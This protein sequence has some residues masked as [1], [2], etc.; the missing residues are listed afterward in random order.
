MLLH[1]LTLTN[2]GVYRGQ[3]RIR[4]SSTTSRPITLIGGR[5]GAGKTS[6]LDSIPLVLYGSRARRVL[7]G[8]AYPEH[9]NNLVH[10]GERTASIVIAFDRAEEGRQVR[11]VV[12]RT[13][14]RS[15]RGRTTDRLFVSIDGEPRSDLV[16]AWPEFVEGIMPLAV[17]DLAIFDGE[18]I[19]SLADPLSSAAVLRT[20]LYGLLGLDLVDR[21]RTDLQ[22]YRRRAAKAHDSERLGHLSARLHEAEAR[23]EQARVEQD[24]A[25]QALEAAENARTD[26]DRQLQK[27]TDTLE[28]AGGGLLAQRDDLHRRLAEATAASGSTERE[29]VQLATSDLPLTLVPEL[30]KAVVFA[31]ELHEA[32]LRAEQIHDAMAVR[33]SRLALRLAEAL[34]L[35]DRQAARVRELLADDLE[36]IER[37]PLP[38]FSPTSDCAAVASELLHHRGAEL[39]ASAERLTRLLVEQHEEIDRLEATLSAVPDADRIASTVQLVATAEAELRSAERS[40][41]RALLACGDADRRAALAQREAD[42]LA[43]QVLSEGAAD[44]NASRITREVGAADRVLQAFAD[45]MVRKHLGRI[46]H[47][48][49]LALKTLLRKQT[50][51]AGVSIDPTDL[52]VSLLDRNGRSIDTQRLSAGER[53]MMATAVLWGLSRCT[54]MALPTVIDTP[55]GRLDRSHRTNLVDRYFPN[56][57]RQVVLLSTDEEIV[58]GHLE[59]LAPHVG[60]RYR[61]DFDEDEA[62][63]SISKGYLD[64]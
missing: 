39:T 3:Q 64:E 57:S 33:D 37:P 23:L 44:A 49:D 11:Y 54:G 10:H 32:S 48:I 41:E 45:Q 63:T 29:L 38:G 51:V 7:N 12:E 9:L 55:V 1:S 30:L 16:A 21:L 6:L 59:R 13:W 15:S 14:N 20:S 2:V 42:S 27:A 24:A 28:K 58:G 47:E 56:A 61:L 34:S 53:Q 40:V 35:E 18:K 26:L 36:A 31:G 46:T 19:E 52:S 17:A 60:A 4:F 22:S 8:A 25:A 5:N 43:H 62:C 50:L